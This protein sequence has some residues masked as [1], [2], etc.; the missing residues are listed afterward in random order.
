MGHSKHTLNEGGTVM[1]T[2]MQGV[3]LKDIEVV[4]HVQVHKKAFVC[5][6]NMDID[7]EKELFQQD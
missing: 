4:G 7:F 1:P 2:E 5:S 6:Y 3:V